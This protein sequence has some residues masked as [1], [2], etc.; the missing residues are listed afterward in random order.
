L[1]F[2]LSAI[3]YP[4]SN[5][6]LELEASVEVFF[7]ISRAMHSSISFEKLTISLLE[8]P[9]FISSLN[10]VFANILVALSGSIFLTIIS[11]LPLLLITH[12]LP[13]FQVSFRC[14]YHAKHDGTINHMQNQDVVVFQQN[15]HPKFCVVFTID[16]PQFSYCIIIAN[17]IITTP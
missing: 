17:S 8:N 7:F 5:R 15:F 12:P 14:I 11:R 10:S 2:V 1:C 16:E 9:F 3:D 4:I 13:S 6:S